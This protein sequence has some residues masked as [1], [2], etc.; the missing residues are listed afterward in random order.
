M[1]LATLLLPPLCLCE[2]TIAARLLVMFG[3]T[4]G[5]GLLVLVCTWGASFSLWNLVQ[6]YVVMLSYTIAL[7]GLANLISGFGKSPTWRVPSAAIATIAGLLWLTWPVWLAA[8]LPAHEQFARWLVAPHPLLTLNGLFR[9]FG[10]W[11]QR[12]VAYQHLMTLGQ[13]LPYQLPLSIW[14]MVAVHGAVGLL[15]LGASRAG[16]RWTLRSTNHTD[17][18]ASTNIAR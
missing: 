9:E 8:A 16:R 15:L 13:D 2:E 5:I 4:D 3:V 14:P 11:T 12:P 6:A 17:A 1:V 10:I 18:A 7:L